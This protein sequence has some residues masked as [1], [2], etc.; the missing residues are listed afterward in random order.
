[1]LYPTPLHKSTCTCT[2][3]PG[4]YDGLIHWFLV[5]FGASQRESRRFRVSTEP[6][7]WSP[8]EVRVQSNDWND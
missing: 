6:R 3:V 2:G 4:C 5:R 7:P 8:E 1:M